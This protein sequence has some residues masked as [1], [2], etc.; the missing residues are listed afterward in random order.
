MTRRL[1]APAPTGS[2][3]ALVA[4]E[5]RNRRAMRTY[6]LALSVIVLVVLGLVKLAYARGELTHISRA[7][8]AAPAT[9]AG[10]STLAALTLKWHTSDQPASGTPYQDGIVVT[11]AGHTVNGR[12]ALTGVVRW[13]YTRTDETVCQVVQQDSSTLAFYN[14]HGE[15]DEV[16]GF[17]T[18]TGVPKFYRTM[19]DNG[20]LSIAS[21]PNVVMI[22]S[23]TAVH[24]IDNAGGIDRWTWTVPSGCATDRA[25]VG[26]AGALVAFHCGA[27][28]QLLLHALT[29]DKEL[30][31]VT[32]PAAL[33]PL[34]ADAFIA[35]VDPV[36][37]LVTTFSTDKG[38]VGRKFTLG[39]LA[40]LGLAALLVA[41]A[42]LVATDAKGAS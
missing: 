28:H 17:T 15:C 14:H 8:A 9:I 35:A 16:T 27:S 19:P 5:R 23:T 42:S 33:L 18:A 6:W 22:V 12:D 10:S 20:R 13:H 2:H 11:Y 36:T 1:G 39:S 29:A 7:D 34:D 25:L 31:T 38:A 24:V 32:T 30:W 21:A 3:P 37:G 41:Q 26:S 40:G 4:Y